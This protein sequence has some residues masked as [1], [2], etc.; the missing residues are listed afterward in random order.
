MNRFT[1]RIN[2][3]SLL[4]ATMSVCACILLID[5]QAFA[6]T[7]AANQLQQDQSSQ[8]ASISLLPLAE[9]V[10][11]ILNSPDVGESAGFE[12]VI[13]G[14][15]DAAGLLSNVTITQTSGDAKVKQ[16]GD[17]FVAALNN[18]RLLSFLSEA[19][20]LRL[21]IGSSQADVAASATYKSESAGHASMMAHGY[22]A[23]FYSAASMNRGRDYEQ[24]YR[25]LKASSNG[26]EVTIA[27]S[28]PR[29]TFCALLSKY[30]SSN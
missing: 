20:H 29:E 13:E 1:A 4:V 28:M 11:H 16:T 18:S 15:R 24:M 22:E 25:S 30:L 26:D 6:Q 9:I 2:I 27:F 8:H 23:M 12:F 10:N 19:K 7:T 17:E 21:K 3:Q 14:D 5:S